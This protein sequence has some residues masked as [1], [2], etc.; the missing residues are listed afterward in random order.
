MDQGS[1][2]TGIE[3]ELNIHPFNRLKANAYL[4]AQ[5][6]EIRSA[7]KVDDKTSDDESCDQ[8]HCAEDGRYVNAQ[9]SR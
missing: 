9:S 7:S 6:V 4:E 5:A 3:Q 1:S 8:A 2:S